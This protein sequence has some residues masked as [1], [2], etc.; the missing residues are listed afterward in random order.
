MLSILLCLVTASMAF[1]TLYFCGFAFLGALGR[2]SGPG[3]GAEPPRFLPRVAI[4]VPG[5][6][7]G[8]VLIRNVESL[9]RQDY[10]PDLRQVIVVA[11]HCD[12]EIV[13]ELSGL[14]VIVH[15]TAFEKST[16]ARSLRYALERLQ[17]DFDAVA[18]LD[19]DNLAHPSF[20]QE[21]ARAF[22]RGNLAI[23]GFRKEKNRDST[24]ARLEAAMERIN[25]VVYRQGRVEAGL[26]AA[27]AGS[28]MFFDRALF[29]DCM[30]VVDAVG[31]FDKQLE[32]EIIL[33]GFCI[34]WCPSAVVYDE[35]VDSER[36]FTRQ[37]RRWISTSLVFLRRFWLRALR[38]ALEK[39]SL[40]PLDKLTQWFAPP[41]TIHL[42]ILG[43]LAFLGLCPGQWP[44][45][46]LALAQLALMALAIFTALR[47]T[48]PPRDLYRAF[49]DAPRALLA[50][51]R[52]MLGVR[53]ADRTFIHTDH[54]HEVS[55]DDMLKRDQEGGR[56]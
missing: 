6:R 8:R 12:S 13:R 25:H 9:L 1:F 28:G 48:H 20:L 24:F 50:M 10:P 19:A 3:T 38:H 53:G 51:G 45:L 47:A 33:R 5:W 30:E 40:D 42:G 54:E 32:M 37:K 49:L 15:A 26:S 35:K 55:I 56:E 7:E 14:P 31:G 2:R 52:A 36:A 21:M 43:L 23:Q 29:T 18:I 46:V 41:R 22:L 34:G 44:V 17:G 39:R 4:I 11:D 27:L 16:K